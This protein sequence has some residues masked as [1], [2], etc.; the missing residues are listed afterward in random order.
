[1]TARDTSSDWLTKR[2]VLTRYQIGWRRLELW[3][4]DGVVR[5]VK[6][7]DSQ[8]GRRLYCAADIE[9]AL[10]ALATGRTLQRAPGNTHP[11]R[12]NR[13]GADHE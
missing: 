5:S 12:R 1:M 11:S 6:L 3:V 13:K 8:T 9:R 4:Q 2:V 7:C 10:R